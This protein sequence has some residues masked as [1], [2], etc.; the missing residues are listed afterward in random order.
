MESTSSAHHA[1][2]SS[3]HEHVPNTTTEQSPYGTGDAATV[4]HTQYM[5]PV[6]TTTVLGTVLSSR[7]TGGAHDT[8]TLE[9]RSSHCIHPRCRYM[10]VCIKP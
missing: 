5:S 10:G 1:H 2:G 9:L 7:V 8:H 4:Q 6:V 3:T